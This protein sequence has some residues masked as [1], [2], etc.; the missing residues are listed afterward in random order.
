MNTYIKLFTILGFDLLILCV[1]VFLRT[2]LTRLLNIKLS[3]YYLPIPPPSPNRYRAF[4]RLCWKTSLRLEAELT[5]TTFCLQLEPRGA[6]CLMVQQE[7]LINSAAWG[8]CRVFYISVARADEKTFE[9]GNPNLP[10]PF[11]S[12]AFIMYLTYK[13]L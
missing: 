1:T 5:L 12:I 9:T 6:A 13:K 4:H 8:P 11:K 7:I 2:D 3:L 10:C